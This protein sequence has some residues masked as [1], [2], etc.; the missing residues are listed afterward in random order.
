MKKTTAK[1]TEAASADAVVIY[2]ARRNDNQFIA[3]ILIMERID[4]VWVEHRWISREE[5][6]DL[7]ESKIPVHVKERGLRVATLTGPLVDVLKVEGVKYIRS[8]GNDE[9]ED[10]LEVMADSPLVHLNDE[11]DQDVVAEE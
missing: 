8:R 3:E 1:T 2:D 7:I 6:V 9:T 5:A 4:G 11:Q 10:N